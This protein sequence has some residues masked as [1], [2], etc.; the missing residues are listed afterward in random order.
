M[1]NELNN[2][3]YENHLGMRF[4]SLENGVYL[5][6]SDILNYSWDYDVINNRISRFYRSVTKRGLP[7]V[8]IG[9]TEEEA[10]T[11]K[12]RLLEIAEAD[13]Q[14]MLPGK[15]YVG[16]YYTSGFITASKKSKYLFNKRYCNLNLEF[17][18]ADPAWYTERNYV[19]GKESV[20]DPTGGYGVDFP[21]DF[22]FDYSAAFKSRKINSGNIGSSK[23]KLRIYGEATN[24]IIN[25][26]GHIYAINGSVQEKESLLINSVNKTITLT[27]AAGTKV[28]WFDKRNRE[29]YIF[30]PIPAGIQNVNHSGTFEFDLTVIE[31]RSEPKWT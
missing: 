8:V 10:I 4:E 5:N 29:S 22:P 18:S 17:T 25:I 14:A 30:E 7:L 11:A 16:E 6:H 12:N 1:L 28:N 3:V 27:T 26:A 2:F 31:E 19:F 21:F 15:I 23:F 9:K 13:I 24:P 20:S